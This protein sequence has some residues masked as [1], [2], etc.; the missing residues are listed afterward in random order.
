MK[1][2]KSE[3][4]LHFNNLSLAY[5]DA[6]I[7]EVQRHCSMVSLGLFRYTTTDLKLGGF[8]IPKIYEIL[9]LT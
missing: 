5:L 6:T 1:E 3:D 4:F 8:D 9:S 2:G 7:N